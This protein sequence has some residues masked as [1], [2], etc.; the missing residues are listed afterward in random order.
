MIHCDPT[1]RHDFVFL[2]DVTNGNPNGDPDAGNLPRVDAETN[3]GIVTDVCIKRKIRDYAQGVLKRPIF[4]QGETALNTLYSRVLDNTKDEN[5]APMCAPAKV[6]LADDKDLKA[7]LDAE[8]LSFSE[9]LEAV[10]DDGFLFDPESNKVEYR[11]E[12]KKASDI[13]K[14]L[15]GEDQVTGDLKK[16]VAFLCK[17]LAES[18][19]DAKVTREARTKAKENMRDEYWDVCMFGAVLTGGTNA[20]QIRG[21]MQLTFATSVDPIIPRDISI[22]RIA[23]TKPTDMRRKTTEMGR[24]GYVPYGLYRLHGFFNPL[25]GLRSGKQVVLQ[26]HLA[27]FWEAL[28]NMFPFDRSAARGE[29]TSRGLYVFTHDNVKG[30]AP[31][32]RLFDLVKIAARGDSTTRAF[33]DYAS[34]I[35]VPPAGILTG[36]LG[37]QLTRVIHHEEKKVADAPGTLAGE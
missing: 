28:E 10:D 31:S 36:F 8:D 22:T 6:S 4:I 30:N 5:G 7:Y 15:C 26:E 20:G 19:K 21:P 14:R 27:D 37:V 2:F 18:A 3:H 1:K 11:G 13:M 23:I 32:H 17:R 9:W 24:K 12:E 29:M 33:S 25:L 35:T 34:G 16:A